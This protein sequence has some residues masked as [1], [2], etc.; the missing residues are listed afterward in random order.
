MRRLPIKRIRQIVQ[1]GSLL[2]FLYLFFRT[3]Y[4][5]TS[6]IPV[7]LFLRIDPLVALGTLLSGHAWVGKMLWS[8]VLLG[9]T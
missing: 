7:D 3:T 9:A 6:F 4:P 1:A 2:F 8:L 5:L